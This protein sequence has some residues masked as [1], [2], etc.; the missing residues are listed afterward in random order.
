MEYWTFWSIFKVRFRVRTLV[1]RVRTLIFWEKPDF[2]G[3]DSVRTPSLNSPTW[4]DM[5]KLK[6]DTLNGVKNMTFNVGIGSVS[7]IA[8]RQDSH[9][10]KKQRK[11]IPFL[12]T[13]YKLKDKRSIILASKMK[14]EKSFIKDQVPLRL[15][16][17]F[18]SWFY[19]F[20]LWWFVSA[21]YFVSLV[22][23]QV[24]TC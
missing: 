22:F 14:Q 18:M 2:F 24:R 10:L 7:L 17:V 19:L 21:F 8:A 9:H 16:F 6:L 4:W 11:E 13:F 1:L 15:K 12:I 5:Q 3:P 20:G 23:S